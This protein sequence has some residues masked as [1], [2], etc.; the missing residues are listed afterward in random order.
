MRSTIDIRHILTR[1]PCRAPRGKWPSLRS[2]RSASCAPHSPCAVFSSFQQFFSSPGT[3]PGHQQPASSSSGYDITE[4]TRRKVIHV[5]A[6]R[7]KNEGAVFTSAAHQHW[8][9]GQQ[10]RGCECRQPNTRPKQQRRASWA[11]LR[12]GERERERERAR[13]PAYYAEPARNTEG[14]ER[15]KPAHGEREA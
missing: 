10:D 3:S 7:D 6:S 12:R 15:T 2:P 5:T 14:N 8:R 4:S 1:S 13:S 11:E 9:P